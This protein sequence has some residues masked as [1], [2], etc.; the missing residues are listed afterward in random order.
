MIDLDSIATT[1]EQA[2][3]LSNRGFDVSDIL[4]G[5]A[6]VLRGTHE[7][8]PNGLTALDN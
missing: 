1:L 5:L 7:P 8:S 4:N 6:K 3:L 2:A